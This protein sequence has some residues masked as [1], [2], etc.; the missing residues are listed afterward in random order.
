MEQALV[1]INSMAE[2]LG[3]KPSWLYSETRKRGGTIPV[4]R[5]GKY[6]RFDPAEV[7][8]WLKNQG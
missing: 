7:I 6:L 8:E 5:V 3:I 1:D 2:I 4:L